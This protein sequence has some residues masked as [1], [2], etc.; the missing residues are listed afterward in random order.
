MPSLALRSAT[1]FHPL[2][3]LYG[4]S[5]THPWR[6]SLIRRS[7]RLLLITATGADLHP[8]VGHSISIHNQVAATARAG[9][10]F[11]VGHVRAP[12]VFFRRLSHREITGFVDLL[13]TGPRSS[14]RGFSQINKLGLNYHSPSSHHNRVSFDQTDHNCYGTLFVSRRSSVW[15]L[16]DWCE[17]NWK[18]PT[19]LRRDDVAQPVFRKQIT[20]YGISKL[21]DRNR[22][23]EL[24]RHMIRLVTTK[25]RQSFRIDYSDGGGILPIIVSTRS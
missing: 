10:R 20:Q 14:L 12:D 1:F 16:V 4:H 25:E 24:R 11:P 9:I 17:S 19:V 23:T 2:S 6:S 21:I 7:V 15:T 3:S 22:P 5:L 8:S 18:S 13:G